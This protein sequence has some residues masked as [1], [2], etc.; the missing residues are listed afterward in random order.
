LIQLFITSQ[1]Y[2]REPWEA[3]FLSIINFSNQLFHL[4]DFKLP[5]TPL[6]SNKQ[7]SKMHFISLFTPVV[8]LLATAVSASPIEKR[9]VTADQMVTTINKITQQSKSL[10]TIA[11]K[12]NPMNGVPLLGPSSGSGSTNF[13]D[14]ITG[15]QG[16]IT[17]GTTAITNME[18]TQPY[19]NA[20]EEQKVCDAFADVSLT[21]I[22]V[23]E[24]RVV[25]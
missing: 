9:A 22:C 5:N 13:N 2:K 10:T 12:I 16:I 15:F 17:T 6:H 4:T 20:A 19:T 14:V 25:Y 3:V 7:S 24:H 8:A 23:I 18:G 1:R 21:T 11:N